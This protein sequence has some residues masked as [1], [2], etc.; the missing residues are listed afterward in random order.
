MKKK[1]KSKKS[2]KIG[3]VHGVFDAIH[4]GHLWY[5]KNA[6]KLVDKLIV[7]V[8]TDK[9]VNKGP[10]KPIFDTAKRVELLRSIDV[11]DEVIVSDSKTAIEIIKKIKPDFYIKGSDYKNLASDLSNQIRVE[12][13]AVESIGGK[14]VFT[15]SP[16]F[17][18][19]SIINKNFDFIN[20][21]AKKFL[22]LYKG[23]KYHLHKKF[24][25]FIKTKSNKKI[26]LIGDPLLDIIK[27]VLPSGKSNKNNIIAT[28]FVNKE[29][30]LGG[31]LLVLNFVSQFY[32]SVE[33]LFVGDK[34]EFN[35]LKKKINKNVKINFIL[36]D[37]KII[38]KNRYIDTYN[39]NKFFQVN[40]NE[41]TKLSKKTQGKIISFAKEKFKKVDKILF[42]D[43]GYNYSYP[44]M[45]VL[46]N[47]FSNK[48][49]L[50]CQTNSYNFGFNLVSKYK[51]SQILGIDENELRLLVQ[52]KD[53]NL[54]H[55]IKNNK[56][57]F[58]GI[59]T[60][61]ITQGKVGCYILKNNK[62]SFIPTILKPSIDTTGSGDIFLSMFSILS[63]AE[64]FEVEEIS[65]ISHVAAGLH[66]NELG[67]R[68]NL[69]KKY[70]SNILSSVLK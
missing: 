30:N 35:F 38:R 10:G 59:K 24:K 6:K 25:D 47:K 26:I 41:D 46:L 65:I 9:Y 55:I 61:I 64:K 27:F 23:S 8:T 33:F 37:N 66:A 62:I 49:I 70:I 39:N 52:D 15:N 51:K 18:S 12:K 7:S 43:Y 56:N 14:L 50:N 21:D 67:N 54:Q 53:T 44:E 48:L 69:D 40:E 36:S 31:T 19:S 13:R 58:K 3:L 57:L 17:S 29:I 20:D 34:K 2:I 28:R 32:K 60:F 22:T 1:I 16:L 63:L 4:I 42:F 45:R 5:F 68:F 11:I